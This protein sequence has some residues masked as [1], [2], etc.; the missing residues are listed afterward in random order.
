MNQSKSWQSYEEVARYLLNQIASEFGLD[1][2]EEKQA[3]AGKT[4]GTSWEIDARGVSSD[5]A[6]FVIIEIRRYLKSRLSQESLAAIAFRIQDT[7]AAGGIVVSPLPLQ[8]G[9]KKVA[10]CAGVVHVQLDA[11]STTERYILRFLNNVM[12]GL[13]SDSKSVTTTVLTGTLTPVV[14]YPGDDTSDA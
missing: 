6:G 5:G 4:S 8:T 3:V 2:V 10:D 12:V 13:T 7:G 11:T 14:S 9:A 1:R